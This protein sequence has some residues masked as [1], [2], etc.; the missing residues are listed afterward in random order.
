MDAAKTWTDHILTKTQTNALNGRSCTHEVQSW[1]Q[2]EEAA[3][4]SDVVVVV[5]WR[6]PGIQVDGRPLLHEC[7]RVGGGYL[8]H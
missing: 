4:F 3:T 1:I 2:W 6:G 5:L 7:F 8:V